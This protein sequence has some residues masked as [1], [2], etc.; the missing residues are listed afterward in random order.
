MALNVISPKG[1]AEFIIYIVVCF[2]KTAFSCTTKYHGFLKKQSLNSV[3]HRLFYFNEFLRQF[4]QF[5]LWQRF[6]IFVRN[7]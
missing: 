1:V 5:F 4:I 6:K 7:F 3:F 2:R